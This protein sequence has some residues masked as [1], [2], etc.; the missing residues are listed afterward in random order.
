LSLTVKVTVGALPANTV[1]HLHDVQNEAG[2]VV[3]S[4]AM[5]CAPLMEAS[6]S[7]S[8][9]RNVALAA[10]VV[11]DLRQTDVV[12][13]SGEIHV[14][15]AGAA[16]RAVGVLEPGIGLYRAGLGRWLRAKL[17]TARIGGVDPP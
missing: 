7:S 11:G 4:V 16:S 9:W 15:V 8:P 12:C 1:L 10:L 14:V 5:V 2:A 13:A 6:N 3:D 17:A